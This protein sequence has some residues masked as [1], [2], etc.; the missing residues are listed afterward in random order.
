MLGNFRECLGMLGNVGECKRMFGNVFKCIGYLKQGV[1]ERK[2]GIK[3]NVR[4]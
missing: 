2:V 3:G 1:E 4:K